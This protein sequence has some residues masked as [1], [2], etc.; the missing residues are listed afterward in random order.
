[1][2]IDTLTLHIIGFIINK[3]TVEELFVD[4]EGFVEVITDFMASLSGGWAI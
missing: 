2:T 3:C 1:M 4:S